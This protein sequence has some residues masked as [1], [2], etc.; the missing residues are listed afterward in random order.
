MGWL[1]RRFGVI[2]YAIELSDYF[3]QDGIGTK[4]TFYKMEL[5]LNWE[6]RPPDER[7]LL[8]RAAQCL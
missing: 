4:T 2:K 3:L 6:G 8:Q 7:C 5:V 1:Y